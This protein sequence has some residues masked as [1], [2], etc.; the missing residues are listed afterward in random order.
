[1][2]V[3]VSMAIMQMRTVLSTTVIKVIKVRLMRTIVIVTE[4][5]DFG[6]DGKGWWGS[7]TDDDSV[8]ISGG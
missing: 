2:L 5:S 6:F 7:V 8:P 1:M 3:V 4:T